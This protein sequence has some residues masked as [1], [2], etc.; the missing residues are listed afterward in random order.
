[1]PLAQQ[2]GELLDGVGPPGNVQDADLTGRV[3]CR[4]RVVPP[5]FEGWPDRR[6]A[7]IGT[8]SPEL[9]E[10][11]GARKYAAPVTDAASGTGAFEGRPVGSIEGYFLVPAY[12]RGY[13]WGPSEVGRLLDDINDSHGSTYYLQPIV[14]KRLTDDRWELV[15]GQQRLTTLFLIFQFI[16]QSNLFPRAQAHYTLEYE[17]RARS[18]E[19]LLC[20][21]EDGAKA[22]IDFFHIYQAWE[23]IRRWF[24]GQDD[25]VQAAIDLHTALARRVQ[26]IW[27]EAPED[28]DSRALF[29]RLN[30]GRI[31]LTD[32]ELVKALV[33]SRSRD[34][35]GQPDRALSVA[36]EW[37]S[38]ERDLRIPELW[39]FL[40]GHA[41]PQ[42]THIGL[43][44]DT[45]AGGPLGLDRPPFH[46]FEALRPVIVQDPEAFWDSV[47][48]LHSR[49]LG[50][51]E[52]RDL[53]HKIGYLVA[54]GATFRAIL[55]LA[56]GARRSQFEQALDD[57]IR[58]RLGLSGSRLR[59][60]SYEQSV[61]RARISNAL[62]LLNV[63]TIRNA[64]NSS[65]R[66]SFRAHAAG[67]WSLEHIHAQNAEELRTVD[68]WQSWLRLHRDALVALPR[69]SQSQR[70][71][72]EARINAA[73]PSVTEETFH[74]LE[75]EISALFAAD[76]TGAS[77]GDEHGLANL[78]LLDLHDNIALSNSVFEV[79]RL[80]VLELDRAGSYIP[81]C[82]RN[83]FLKYYTRE[84][85]QQ[86]HYWSAQDRQDYLTEM[87]RALRPYLQEDDDEAVKG[88]HE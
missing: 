83:V 34:F 74:A 69:L 18:A 68:Q 1:M 6:G 79:K 32:A 88:N 15:D 63:E 8:P 87:E 49:V 76:D 2:L 39:A 86:L 57:Q 67:E 11:V 80:A 73:I 47:V 81:V 12:Q 55:A 77:E 66:Y 41:N 56:D 28:V 16:K 85:A 52:D 31:P 51:F 64:H 62:L 48:D 59:E 71:D 20:P 13:R 30:V 84:P 50:W 3:E 29:T 53:F 44:L 24:A 43:L 37:D 35:I 25:E 19:Y 22:N 23:C 70:S 21:D 9:P 14:V 72:L 78:A 54:A 38:I 4:Q 65:E 60:L 36:A 33:L 46:T 10:S 45:L 17:T 27:Y 5:P 7:G 82:T 40:T 26:V 75:Q 61:D 42:A 58:S